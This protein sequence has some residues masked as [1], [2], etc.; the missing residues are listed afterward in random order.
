MP[1]DIPRQDY[2]VLAELLKLPKETTKSLVKAL[3]E[4][5]PVLFKKTLISRVSEKTQLSR[6]KLIKLMNIIFKVFATYKRT[7]LE[8]DSFLKELRETLAETKFKGLTFRDDQWVE[9]KNFLSK[10]LCCEDSI[11]VT[12]KALNVMVDH[13]RIFRNARIITDLRPV[14]RQDPSKPPA[15]AVTIHTLKIEYREDNQEKDFFVALDSMDIAQ[16]E[17]LVARAKLKEVALKNTLSSSTI[18][19]LES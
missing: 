6:S 14:F 8:I 7:G 16:L 2:P 12:E 15:A 10:I 13:A 3:Q 17:K 11:G 18:T 19:I 5:P 4:E 1:L 9:R